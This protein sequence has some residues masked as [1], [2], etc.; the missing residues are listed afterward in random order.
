MIKVRYGE[1]T[2]IEE[3]EYYIRLNNTENQYDNPTYTFKVMLYLCS[4]LT[5]SG[6]NENKLIITSNDI[7][8]KLGIMSLKLFDGAINYISSISYDYKKEFKSKK[9]H[10]KC[11]WY[12]VDNIIVSHKHF[13]GYYEIVFSDEFLILFGRERKQFFYTIPKELLN[14]DVRYKVHSVFIGNYIL[15]H[16]R[17][18][19]GKANELIISIKELIKNCPL[20]PRYDELGEDRQ[21]SRAIIEPFKNNLDFACYLLGI[22]WHYADTEPNNYMDFIKAKVVLDSRN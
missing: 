8:N 10:T 1:N 11:I 9:S 4:L 16:Q 18:N 3:S 15:L 2:A 6:L 5:E 21:V 20:L 14:C 19:K 13:K 17:R 22:K 12:S 7:H